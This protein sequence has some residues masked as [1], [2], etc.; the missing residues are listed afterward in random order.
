MDI[1]PWQV[2]SIQDF[3]FL[4]CPECSFDTKE[5]DVFQ[6]HAT[7]NHPLS[8]VF[9]NRTS[10]DECFEHLYT[11][12]EDSLDIAEASDNE[13]KPENFLLST[14]IVG[15]STNKPEDSENQ[16]NQ[17][18]IASDQFLKKRGPCKNKSEYKCVKCDV[19]FIGENSLNEHI[20]FFHEGKTEE[21]EYLLNNLDL[22]KNRTVT[23]DVSN[24]IENYDDSDG[25]ENL[26]EENN[27]DNLSLKSSDSQDELSIIEESD[28]S[29]E[30][31]LL[32]QSICARDYITNHSEKAHEKEKLH[33]CSICDYSAGTSSNLR[34]HIVGVHR[35]LKKKKENIDNSNTCS[36]CG[37]RFVSD[38]YL[39]LHV[40]KVH[41]KIKPL[42]RQMNSGLSRFV[43][44]STLRKPKEKVHT[45]VHEEKKSLECSTCDYVGNNKLQL[46]LHI[47]DVHEGKKPKPIL[48]P[49][50]GLTLKKDLKFHIENVHEGKK[51]HVCTTCGKAFPDIFHLN[52]HVSVVHEQNKSHKCPVC[53]KGFGVKQNLDNHI[54]GVHE[55]NKPHKCTLCEY[56]C[57]KRNLLENHIKEVHEENKPFACSLCNSKF[58]LKARL[59]RHIKEVHEKQNR[60][61]CSL[62][63]STFSHIGNL[64]AH[65]ASVH[66]GKKSKKTQK[67]N[68]LVT[69]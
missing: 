42:K 30:I 27:S 40:S 46:K 50:C 19:I 45:D 52:Q 17:V 3:S 21:E 22:G 29:E 59:N 49:I 7:E 38:N 9:F 23:D 69:E 11:I 36:I 18:Q 65:I 55:K 16:S 35:Q 10:K 12:E 20:F 48:C 1:N 26:D 2:E 56:T 5:E 41:K 62:C 37:K 68:Q 47:D 15:E 66:E 43:D 64:N 54:Q 8:F 25:Y 33:K 67:E 53:G 44:K 39:Y 51:P 61:T 60:Q 14:M 13:T 24:E 28:N 58:G 34:V 31:R 63:S 57:M 32:K 4:K 6:D